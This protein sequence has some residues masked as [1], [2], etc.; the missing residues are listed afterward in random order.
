MRLL[1]SKKQYSNWKYPTKLSFWGFWIGLF[2]LILMLIFRAVDLGSI[3]K[4]TDVQNTT[5]KQPVIQKDT[6]SVTISY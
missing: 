2:A 5:S 6:S 1:P 4:S 3:K